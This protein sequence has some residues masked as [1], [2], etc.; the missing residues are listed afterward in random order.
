MAEFLT[1]SEFK[2]RIGKPSATINVV[3]NPK[4]GKLFMD[5]D[6]HY[7]KVQAD[8]NPEERMRVLVPEEG[9]DE[10]CLINAKAPEDNT[11]FSL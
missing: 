7:Y 5:I 2:T 9:I 1:V 8:I 3:K 10:A 4:T 6:G 11:V